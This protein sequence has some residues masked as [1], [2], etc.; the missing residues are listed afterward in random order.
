MFSK[1]MMFS[2]GTGFGLVLA[3]MVSLAVVG[4]TQMSSINGRLERIV[5]ENNKKVELASVMR[6]SL[7]QRIIAMHTI[8]NTHDN[9]EKDEEL[10][11]FY[12]YG[13]NFTNARQKLDQMLSSEEEKAVL[14]RI[15]ALAIRT[16]P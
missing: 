16:Q 15:R 6:D 13:V 7:R 8:V 2:V 12:G 9:F 1:H 3:L 10:Q 11:R 5:N 4:L 14:G